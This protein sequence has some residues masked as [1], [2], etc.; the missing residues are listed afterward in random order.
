RVRGDL[1]DETLHLPGI[2]DVGP[3][4]LDAARQ[5]FSRLPVGGRIEVRRHHAAAE[6]GQSPDGCRTHQAEA[7]GDQDSSIQ[8]SAHGLLLLE[9]CGRRACRR[10]ASLMSLSLYSAVTVSSSKS[11]P[12]R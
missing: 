5:F 3:P 8:L 10:M 11:L 9:Y 1:Q 7:A 2:G 12:L 6:F 4:E